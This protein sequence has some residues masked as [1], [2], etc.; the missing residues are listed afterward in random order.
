[1]VENARGLIGD[2]KEPCR[3][4]GGRSDMERICGSHSAELFGI[5]LG[6]G[7]G[8]MLVRCN[9]VVG[10][11]IMQSTAVSDEKPRMP[12]CIR[13]CTRLTVFFCSSRA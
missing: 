4:W 13:E 2:V 11:L 6:P 8:F 9:K 12:R 3:R 1:M 5:C 7:A 10:V